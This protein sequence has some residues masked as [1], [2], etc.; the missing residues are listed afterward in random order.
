MFTWRKAA[1]IGGVFVVCTTPG[2]AQAQ[3]TPRLAWDQQNRSEVDGYAVTVDGARTDYGLSPQSSG[4]C[5]S[6]PV[7]FSGGRHTIVVTAYNDAGESSSAPFTV[8]PIADAGG[9]YSGAAG[10]A[11]AVTAAGSTAPTGSLTR[12]TWRW[13]DGSA[14][15]TSSSPAASHVYSVGGTFTVTLTV[16]DNAGATASDST[17][18]SVSTT[19]VSLPSP[20]ATRDIGSVGIPGSASYAS[21]SFSVAG[22]GADIWSWDDSFRYVYQPLDGDGEII[23]RV[24]R[25]QNT[26]T[27]AKAGVM[28]RE[29][30]GSGAP[31]AVVDLV[32]SGAIEFLA[33][34]TWGT[35]TIVGGTSTQAPPAWVKLTRN[36]DTFTASV[37]ADG[38][39]W[40]VVGSQIVWMSRAVVVGLAVT[41]HDTSALN[42]SV[43]DN[44]RVTAGSSAQPPSAPTSP[45]PSSGDTGVAM[46]ASL[47]WSALGATSYDVSF[48]TTNPPPQVATGLTTASYRP[49]S[50]AGNTRYFWR[51]VAR[52]SRGTATGSV[53]SF[54]TEPPSN[55]GAVPP[56]WVA[57]DIGWVGLSGSA[58]YSSGTFTIDGS[59]ADIWGRSDGFYY[60]HQPMSGDGQIVARV[61]N[62]DNTHPAAKAG[63]MLRAGE[64]SGAAHVVL[65][66]K[67]DGGI[68]F[69]ERQS[70]GDQTTYMGGASQSRPTWLKLVRAGSTV[71]GYVSANG[72]SWTQVGST[73]ISLGATPWAGLA[74]T[75]H[76]N[77]VLTTATFDSVAVTGG[78]ASPS[79]P[80]SDGD[81]VIHASSIP[82]GA[83]HGSWRS[84]GDWSSPDGV[85]LT[86]PDDGVAITDQPR[87]T[88]TD[89][90]DVTFNAEANKRYRLWLRVKASGDSK[91]NDSLWV[92]FSDALSG[93]S[94]I[95]RMN[96]TSGL[97]VNLATSSDATDLQD[98][99][100][101]NGAYWLWQDTTFT[102]PTTG[103]HTLRIQIRED[104]VQF[105]QI[106]L[107][108]GT[109]MDRAP[110]SVSGDSTIVPND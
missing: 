34:T 22:A 59:G 92:Q 54:T 44:V 40:Q 9:S 85:K 41:S 35:A 84:A 110:G 29:S 56:P 80:T 76:D 73:V 67:P 89:Y 88:P 19:Q 107:S 57:G 82:T 12:Y 30:V 74:V 93:G 78:S 91:W 77:G 28:I 66:V 14:D 61:T 45:T 21:G 81:V 49:P 43:F 109:Y 50:M 8:A 95:Y 86:T 62:M 18:V 5:C 17:L 97:L 6:I 47:S 27:W 33:R 68:E 98:W 72:S 4:T 58:A 63:I 99:G 10:S 32:P 52:N 15:T 105:D 75:S 31:N 20:W 103:M 96:T 48:G 37:S 13:G 16:T 46:S 83:R 39:D 60:V 25:M 79:S 64:D 108:P 70:Q 7:P 36:G 53:W 55:G 102:F 90:V 24:V 100:W 42:A 87:A 1:A 38:S 101:Q 51:V 71:S 2:L 26:N 11:I 104:G 69:M 106:V 3:S 65:D 23:A 94:P